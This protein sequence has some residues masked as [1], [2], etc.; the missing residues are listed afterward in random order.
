MVCR[1]VRLR[2]DLWD[3]SSV[4]LKVES[5]ADRTAEKSVL[6]RDIVT[7]RWKVDPRADW[8]AEPWV[9]KTAQM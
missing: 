7:A 6:R 3:D 9:G 5:S 2:A 1:M 4:D 8:M